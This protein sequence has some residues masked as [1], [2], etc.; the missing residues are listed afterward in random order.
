MFIKLN[1]GQI[2]IYPYSINQLKFDN[3]QVSFPSTLS[4]ELLSEYEVYKVEQTEFPTF[5]YK[6]MIVEDVPVNTKGIWKQVWKVVDKQLEEINSIQE[7]N[8]KEAYREESDPLFFKWQRGEIDKQVW[9]D[10][11]AEI[12]ALWA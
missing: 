4:D 12:K 2:E 11:V 6:Q 3:P 1:N 7:S 10:K 5:T 8:R 9:L